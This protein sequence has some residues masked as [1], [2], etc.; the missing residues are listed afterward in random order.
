[1]MRVW[2]YGMVIPGLLGLAALA[3]IVLPGDGDDLTYTRLLIGC[4]SMIAVCIGGGFLGG[5]A[6]GR[7]Q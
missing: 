5:R 3:A 1:M 4:G 7:H 6:A 2:L